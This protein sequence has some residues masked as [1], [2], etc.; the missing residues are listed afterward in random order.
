MQDVWYSLLLGIL[1][2]ITEFIPVSSSGHLVLV[3]S[4]LPGFEVPG[5]LF[6]VILHAGSLLAV[7]VYFK[8]DLAWLLQGL[9]KKL[10]DQDRKNARSWLRGVFIGTLPAG[11]IGVVA[12]DWFEYLFDHPLAVSI[13]LCCT[14]LI[15]ILGEWL[16]KKNALHSDSSEFISVKMAV[17]VGLTQSLAL[18]PG[19]SRS[20]STIAAGMAGNWSREKAARFSFLL[21]IPAV[22]GAV[23]LKAENIPQFLI[24]SQINLT[25]LVIG[26]T[27]SFAAGYLSIAFLLKVIRKYSF[28][29]FAIYC[30]AVGTILFVIQIVIL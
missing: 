21:M 3:R 25:A 6:E 9:M 13:A 7:I 30:I 18:I 15:L 10:S 16:Q 5:L 19:I 22:A 2:G 1:Q 24:E 27:A 29:P 20:G 17:W 12:H 14:G 11:L 23:L 26:F 8:S 4:V 28:I